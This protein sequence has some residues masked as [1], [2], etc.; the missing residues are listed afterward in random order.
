MEE[1][2]ADERNSEI[3]FLLNGEERRAA[4][5]APYL[6][7]LDY[8][9]TVENACGTKEGCGE[10]DCGACTVAIGD[11]I[12]GGMRYRAVNSCVAFLG[13]ADGK[14]IL[15]VEGLAAADG[16]LHP[17]QQAL[18]DTHA[19]QCGFCTPG[20]VMAMFAFHHGLDA[21]DRQPLDDNTIHDVLAGNLCR[22]TGYRPIVDAMRL[23]SDRPAGDVSAKDAA[24]LAK[25]QS[26]RTVSPVEVGKGNQRFFV[27]QTVEELAALLTRNPSAHILAG[28]TDLGLLVAKH[29]SKPAKIILISEIAEL[30]EIRTSAEQIIIGAAATYADILPIL[31]PE[32][33][34]LGT[35][36][37]RFGSRQIRNLGTVGGNIA[38][39]SPIGDTPPV[40]IAL[41]ARIEIGSTGGSREVDAEDFF[42]AYRETALRPGEFVKSIR[43]PRLKQNEL[44][45][46]Y[47][48][49]RR[50][51]QD[52]SA[53][54][55]AFKLTRD[56]DTIT[57][58]RVAYGGMAATPKRA[59]TVEAV[60]VGRTW[61]RTAA[62]AA[63]IEFASDYR[64][65]TDFRGTASYRLKAAANLIRRF[66]LDTAEDRQLTDIYA[67]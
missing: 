1:P 64:P 19:S 12:D 33:P 15:T 48:L 51:D 53:V 7:I 42:V 49:S 11:P 6:T 37:R 17:V 3:R 56:G 39:A 43:L 67:L 2:I 25:L 23:A 29:N 10:G 35:L 40:L 26:L 50:Y 60:L 62:A 36:I 16:T 45:R 54:C 55:G 22:C 27:P 47:K 46:T 30:H 52:I 57:E 5:F 28:G 18:V 31:D 41:G 14:E 20:F 21:S 34:S 59:P 65:I 66:Q 58:A 61:D 4:D 63:A 32:Y 13:Q 24:T 8:L 9:R 44:F 38:T